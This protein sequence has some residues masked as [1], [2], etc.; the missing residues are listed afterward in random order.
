[1]LAAIRSV[2]IEHYDC[3]EIL[4]SIR[5]RAVR[6]R[7]GQGQVA[8]VERTSKPVGILQNR[9]YSGIQGI[10]RG[11]LPGCILAELD[12]GV[13]AE[14]AGLSIFVFNKCIRYLCR[15]GLGVS[16]I[17]IVNAM[18]SVFCEILDAPE[19][20]RHYRDNRD[21]VLREVG[22]WMGRAGP[23]RETF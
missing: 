16:E 4:L 15:S 22:V 5:K 21:Q 8:V 2:R 17:D 19:V 6:V 20:V 9:L 14:L 12:K 3:F 11:K 10:E 23:L 7:R 13:P 18:Y 1:M